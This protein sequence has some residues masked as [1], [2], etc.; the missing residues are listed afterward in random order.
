MK[1]KFLPI[2]LYGLKCFSLFH[3]KCLKGAYDV[4]AHYYDTLLS[5]LIYITFEQ[6]IFFTYDRNVFLSLGCRVQVNTDGTE[7]SFSFLIPVNVLEKHSGETCF[8]HTLVFF[9]IYGDI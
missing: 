4:A 6:C 5:I 1:L 9:V 7:P 3:N 8:E 2:I